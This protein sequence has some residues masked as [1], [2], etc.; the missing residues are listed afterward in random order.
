M[1]VLSETAGATGKIQQKL[2]EKINVGLQAKHKQC[3]ANGWN[4]ALH[5][6]I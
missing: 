2:K 6:V 4:C 1:R 5:V 3:T